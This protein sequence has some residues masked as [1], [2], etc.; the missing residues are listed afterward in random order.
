[1]RGYKIIVRQNDGDRC[2]ELDPKYIFRLDEKSC[3]AEQGCL[4]Y[5]E[6]QHLRHLL[7]GVIRQNLDLHVRNLLF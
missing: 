2:V 5:S 4:N 7:V 1:M 3:Q 6:I